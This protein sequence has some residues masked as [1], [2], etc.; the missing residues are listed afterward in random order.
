MV[1]ECHQTF[2]LG[3]GSGAPADPARSEGPK[4]RITLKP[5]FACS[6]TVHLLHKQN[7]KVCS[8][9][10]LQSCTQLFAFF[11]SDFTK[12]IYKNCIMSYICTPP[13]LCYIS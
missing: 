3:M 6:R 10:L 13:Q 1:G 2:I 9:E 11:F 5:C 7:N 8:V 4:P 12:K